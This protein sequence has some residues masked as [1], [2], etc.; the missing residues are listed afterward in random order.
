MIARESPG[1][2]EGGSETRPA[3]P[4]LVW[5]VDRIG[6]ASVTSCPV[7]LVVGEPPR[8]RLGLLGALARPPR[9]RHSW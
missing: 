7:F 1:S 4:I 3:P 5:C 9:A 8:G 2:N 6:R